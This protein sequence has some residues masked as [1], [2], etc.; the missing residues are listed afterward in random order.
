LKSVNITK[1]LVNLHHHH[2]IVQEFLNS[3]RFEQLVETS[4]EEKLLGT[5]GTLRNHGE[6]FEKSTTLLIHSDNWCQCNFS[7][8]LEYHFEK[9]PKRCSITMMTFESPTPETCGIVETDT[10][11]V[12]SAFHE[13][14]NNPPGNQ[15]NGAVYLL[16][17]EVI[18]WIDEQPN[19]S[20]F[21]TEVLP[22]Y[23]GHIATWSNC[24]IH[25]DIG[26]LNM[27]KLAQSDY[28]PKYRWP[29]KDI[30]HKKF[31]RN[32]IH[33]QIERAVG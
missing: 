24:R 4:F 20:D 23:L 33:K 28:H 6:F 12:V 16:E 2:E 15:A 22:N 31:M 1:V 21:S 30:W 8:F 9:R 13:K 18:K 29:E 17:P 10:D 27:L 19:I 26:T 32:P 11:G 25:R 14:I 7:D 5:A 3:A